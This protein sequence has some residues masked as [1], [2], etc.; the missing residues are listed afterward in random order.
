[1]VMLNRFD[2]CLINLDPAVGSEL[3]KT[4]PCVIVSPDSMNH[5]RLRTV[6]IAPLTST[7]RDRYPTR[8]NT[9]FQGRDGQVA[10]DQL[11]VIDRERIAK[12][13][14]S[15]NKTSQNEILSILQT[16]FS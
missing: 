11:R 16:M 4:R 15:L 5:S 1:M 9:N 13:L 10:L 12:I 2:V 14:G 7:I 6:I 8:T 3:K